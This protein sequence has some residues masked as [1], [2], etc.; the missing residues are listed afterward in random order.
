[1][2]RLLNFSDLAVLKENSRLYGRHGDDYIV[3]TTSHLLDNYTST[4]PVRL[5]G[6]GLGL[7]MLREGEIQCEIDL[8]SYHI[9]APAILSVVSKTV[10]RNQGHGHGI[11]DCLFVSPRFIHDLNIDLSAINLHDMIDNPPRTVSEDI[12]EADLEVF[13]S[14]FRL[15]YRNAVDDNEVAFSKNI[16]RSVM[17][18]LFYQM[19]QYNN[20]RSTKPSA[21][22]DE[23][24][25]TRQISYVHEFMRLLQLHHKIHRSIQF[26]ADHM[27][28]SSKYLSHIIKEA[29]GRSASEWIAEFVVMEA[30]N[31]LRYS[32]KNIQQ[33]AYELNF[34][35]Q[36][37]F[38]KY[39]KHVTGLSPTEFQKT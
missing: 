37:S 2:D 3:C 27:C 28:I 4:E 22:K 31:M 16:G 8:K 5:A 12:T 1:M 11:V 29:T 7:C 17:Q 24:L 33:V 15:L 36:S 35:T 34:T 20:S 26:Y 25:Q 39:F 13:G 30:K 19:L 6:L 14:Y 18:A 38:G 10:F 21:P 23:G 9:K 32:H